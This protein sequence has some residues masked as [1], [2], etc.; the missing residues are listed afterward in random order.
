MD[1]PTHVQHRILVARAF[2]REEVTRSRTLHDWD[3]IQSK[4]E[5]STQSSTIASHNLTKSEVY[6]RFLIISLQQAKHN[7]HSKQGH[8]LEEARADSY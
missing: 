7:G 1:L 8:P 5:Q 3:K 4:R 6:R 2:I